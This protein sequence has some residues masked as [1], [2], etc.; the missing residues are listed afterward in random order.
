MC[1]NNMIKQ[2]YKNIDR[3]ELH[4]NQNEGVYLTSFGFV[5]VLEGDGGQGTI[6]KVTPSA[7][8]GVEGHMKEKFKAMDGRVRVRI[9]EIIEGGFLGMKFDMLRASTEVASTVVKLRIEYEV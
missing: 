1:I 3:E 2:F 8:I 6:I 9:T 5:E 7:G 4:S